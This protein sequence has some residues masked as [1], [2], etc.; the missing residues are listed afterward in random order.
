RGQPV[1]GLRLLVDGRPLPDRSTGYADLGAGKD[2][3]E[4]EWTVALPPGKH[5]LAVLARSPDASAT[6]P[7]VELNYLA[8]DNLPELHVL[9][10]GIDAYQDKTLRL[11]FA[12]ADAR[13]IAD[14]FKKCCK[15]ALFGDVAGGALV[16]GDA[17]RDKVLEALTELRKRVNREDLVVVSFAGHG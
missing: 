16:D 8:R 5:Q 12:A 13:A 4:V 9:A 3:A 11:Q 6:S 15:G 1:T 17:R 14:A 7:P 2:R 10:I